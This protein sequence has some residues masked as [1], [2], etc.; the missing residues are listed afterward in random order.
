MA[1]PPDKSDAS[2]FNAKSYMESWWANNPFYA[3]TAGY[4]YNYQAGNIYTNAAIRSGVVRT[5]G[6]TNLTPQQRGIPNNAS[7]RASP[8]NSP[9][10]PYTHLGDIKQQRGDIE[11]GLV[12]M[13]DYAFPGQAKYP[14]RDENG[15]WGPNAFVQWLEKRGAGG[16]TMPMVRFRRSK[17]SERSGGWNGILTQSLGSNKAIG[18]PGARGR[19]QSSE[20]S[21]KEMYSTEETRI[22]TRAQFTDEEWQEGTQKWG[23]SWAGF[24]ELGKHSQNPHLRTQLGTMYKPENQNIGFARRNTRQYL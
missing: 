5:G 11:L 2:Q 21:T 14:V 22:G 8:R 16:P 1:R 17:V 23:R 18:V 20:D 13:G 24:K 6:Y 15:N 10:V 4:N 19:G 9:N 7:T 3:T 12:L